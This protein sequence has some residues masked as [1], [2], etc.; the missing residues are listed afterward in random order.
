MKYLILLFLINGCALNTAI[1]P[2]NKV[3]PEFNEYYN[4]FQ[5]KYNIQANTP[6]DFGKTEGTTVAYCSRNSLVGNWIV[7]NEEKWKNFNKT[8]KT[9]IIFH[10][11]G[12]CI[13]NR[14][15]NN[16][17]FTADACPKS[18]M[19]PQLDDVYFCFNKYK[20]YYYNELIGGN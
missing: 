5:E 18:I 9:L 15:H 16:E 1:K 8:G 3:N 2:F 7:V 4:E 17:I 14:P 20:E 10:E 19:Y 11:L 13:L 6:I 12:H